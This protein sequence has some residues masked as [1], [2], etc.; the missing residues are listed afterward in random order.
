MDGLRII[1]WCAALAIV[2]AC[3][4]QPAPQPP[5]QPATTQD[6][7]PSAATE[8]PAPTTAELDAGVADDAPPLHFSKLA[9]YLQAT[10]ACEVGPV[11]VDPSCTAYRRYGAARQRLQVQPGMIQAYA[12]LGQRFVTHPSPVVRMLAAQL[13]TAQLQTTYLQLLVAARQERHPQ[14]LMVLL[15][16]LTEPAAAAGKD[17]LLALAAQLVRHEALVVRVTALQVLGTMPATYLDI[18]KDHLEHG[19]VTEQ[20]AVCQPVAALQPQRVADLLQGLELN[21]ELRAACSAGLVQALCH[22]HEAATRNLAWALLDRELDPQHATAKRPAWQT[23]DALVCATERPALLQRLRELV[24]AENTSG[25]A[26]A[27]AVRSLGKLKAPRDWLADLA[28]RY[29]SQQFG[30]AGQVR[31][32]LLDEGWLHK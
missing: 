26:R 29:E 6:I 5:Q 32:A 7:D 9:G 30:A 19:E 28:K 10:A 12:G 31:R 11:D 14:V 1:A 27:A 17:E 18:L 13:M 23:V 2:T 21:K 8:L 20:I 4:P 24:D 3:K 22:S 16:L 15:T 25:F